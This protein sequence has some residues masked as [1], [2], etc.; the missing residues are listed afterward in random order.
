MKAIF[1]LLA[2]VIVLAGCS[3]AEQQ[4]VSK[5]TETVTQAPKQAQQTADAAS[6]KVRGDDALLAGS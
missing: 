2:G 1:L 5:A 6:A 3:A 4:D